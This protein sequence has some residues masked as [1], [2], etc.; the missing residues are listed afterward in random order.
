MAPQSAGEWGSGVA[1]SVAIVG[2]G[3]TPPGYGCAGSRDIGIFRWPMPVDGARECGL[4][5]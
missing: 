3:P 1:F 2:A 4:R 5:A